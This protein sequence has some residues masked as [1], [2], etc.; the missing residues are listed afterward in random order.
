MRP[1]P[2]R[3]RTKFRGLRTQSPGNRT[4]NPEIGTESRRNS[5]TGQEKRTAREKGH[6]QAYKDTQKEKWISC[7]K[8]GRNARKSKIWKK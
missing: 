8:T 1:F 7:T 3:N 6:F 4:E 5:T 2:G